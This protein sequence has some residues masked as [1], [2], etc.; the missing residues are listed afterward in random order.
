MVFGYNSTLLTKPQ[1]GCYWLCN[2]I[3]GQWY[4]WCNVHRFTN[5]LD[6][7]L[8]KQRKLFKEEN[9]FWQ[10]TEPKNIERWFIVNAT[11]DGRLNFFL[12]HTQKQIQQIFYM[13]WFF[14]DFNQISSSW[15][16]LLFVVSECSTIWTVI[17]LFVSKLPIKHFL[18]KPEILYKGSEINPLYKD[19]SKEERK[20]NNLSGNL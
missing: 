4:S 12:S 16:E 15:N 9:G 2:K 13:E 3:N 6:K 1:Y 17:F 10:H 20:S 14:S 8:P 18:K 7:L 5:H 11:I 19:F